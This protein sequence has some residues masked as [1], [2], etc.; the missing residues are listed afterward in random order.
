MKPFLDKDFLLQ[1]KAA[2]K[3]YDEYAAGMPII[4]YHCHLNPKEIAENLQYDNITQVWL[5]GDHYKWRAMRTLGI[6]EEYITGKASDWEKF[7]KWAEVVPYTVRNPLYHWTHLELQRYFGISDLLYPG[8]AEDIYNQCNEQLQT[9]AFKVRE[10]MKKMKVEIVCTT[11]DPIDDLAY[12]QQINEEGFE[13]KVLPA[14][15]PDK[16]MAVEDTNMYN[17]Y[18]DKLSEVS[19]IEIV[20]YNDFMTAL[21]KRHDCFHKNGCRLSDH[22]IDIFYT[23][24][25]TNR[26]IYKIFR[27]TRKNK[28][29]NWLEIMKFKS[30]LLYEFARMDAEKNWTQQ[31]HYGALRNNN[32]LMFKRLGADSGFDSM[33]DF[34]V[35]R[36][37]VRFLDRLNSKGQLAKTILYNINPKDNEFLASLIGNYNTDA[38]P[39]KMQF[40]SAWWYMDQK[41]GM[42]QQLNALSGIGI[43]SKFVGML[44]D[45]RSFL[46]YPRHEYFR[47]ILCN[48]LGNEMEAGELPDDFELIGKIVQDICYY[49]AKEYFGF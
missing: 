25:Y 4:D 12:H 45:S 10:L 43:L 40:G 5:Y 8:N 2:E 15:R 32:S 11:D 24:E 21:L 42:Q 46:S 7:Q 33:G 1:S 48:L 47:R 49:N 6:D 41:D 20:G 23:E 18:I 16:A 9:E 37:L 14:W 44:T 22:G 27:K 30:T 26:E 35:A 39:G 36:A 3:L 31:F 34:S 28:E 29:L 38:I 19:G 13:I 17:K